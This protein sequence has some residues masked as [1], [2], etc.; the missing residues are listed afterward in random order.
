MPSERR[1]VVRRLGVVGYAEGLEMQ[2]A[3]VARR[4]AGEIDDTLL[5]LQHP[6]ARILAG[7]TDIGLWVNKA[8]RRLDTL[9]HVGRVAELAAITEDGARL[10]IGAG[11]SLQAAWAALARHWPA[12]REMM[13]EVFRGL[14]DAEIEA[15]LGGNAAEFYGFDA[16]EVLFVGAAGQMRN[17]EDW[18]LTFRFEVN[19]NR[20][21]VV[22]AS[23]T[24]GGGPLLEMGT[25]VGF[26]DRDGFTSLQVQATMPAQTV[27]A[28][29]LDALRV[30][31]Q[32][33][34]EPSSAPVLGLGAGLLALGSGMR[35]ADLRGRRRPRS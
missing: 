20:T 4:A 34:P 21:D 11:A 17:A 32:A 22:I 19:E 28:L 7:S 26:F 35:R 33:V 13:V 3:F 2:Q 15:M 12:T 9:I 31:L 10:R 27:Q 23:G 29:A 8:L 16:G 14:P 1:L 25:T 30:Q 5:L 6:Q 24:V 18:Q